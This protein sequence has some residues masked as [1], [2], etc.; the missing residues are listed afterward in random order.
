MKCCCA[1]PVPVW[2]DLSVFHSCPM[3][4]L[5]LSFGPVQYSLPQLGPF[6]FLQDVKRSQVPI[7]RRVSYPPLYSWTDV[8]ATICSWPSRLFPGQWRLWSLG[9]L[10]C[11]PSFVGLIIGVIITSAMLG[12]SAW[13]TT[14]SATRTTSST[15]S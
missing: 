14:T 2:L 8:L 7:N 3:Y 15:T 13:A 5:Q 12:T 4:L 10:A 1:C 9:R 6:L 11:L